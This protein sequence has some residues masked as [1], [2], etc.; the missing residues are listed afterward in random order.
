MNRRNFL[1]ATAASTVVLAAGS[2]ATAAEPQY[3]WIYV[4]DMH[5]S[6][7]AKKITRKLYTVPGV[8]KVQ[9]HL[10]QHFAVITPQAGKSVSP[11]A[12][13][14]AVEQIKFE[15]VKLQG[16]I[17]VYRKKPAV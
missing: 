14:E 6:N 13:W 11:R 2:H 15:P 3:T 9:T 5:C 10:K 4:K 12:V 17:G 1:R 7:C 8:V 16:P